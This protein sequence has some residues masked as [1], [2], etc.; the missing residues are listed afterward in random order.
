M[1]KSNA[2]LE[3]NLEIINTAYSKYAKKKK[4]KK[5]KKRQGKIKTLRSILMI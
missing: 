2:C 4:K 3:E 1:R 5:K